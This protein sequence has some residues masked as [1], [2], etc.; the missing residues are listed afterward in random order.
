MALGA[1]RLAPR[2][3]VV[4][5]SPAAEYILGLDVLQGL[6]AQTTQGEFRLW[7]RVVKTVLRGHA[8]H[9]PVV[10][11]SPARAARV[12][13]YR[14]PGGHE[15]ILELEEAGIIRPP[16]S[17]FHCRVGLA[18]KPDGTWRV[19]VDYQELN[20]VTPPLQAAIPST[21]NLMDS[22]S[23]TLGRYQPLHRRLGKRLFLQRHGTGE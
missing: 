16:L 6:A 5:I 21:M 17:S 19:T 15:A 3:C 9:K 2:A 4:Y 11:P 10:L 22:L 8:H 13:Q 23:L 14:L 7:V 12:R 1:G 18:R 20:R